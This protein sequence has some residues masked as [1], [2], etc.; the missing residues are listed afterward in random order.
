MPDF[1]IKQ[2]PYDLSGQA[3]L[4]LIGKYLKR[5]NF[6]AL[7]DPA[8]PVRS[9]IANSDILKSYLGLLCLGKND[10]DAIEGQRNDAFFLRALSLRAVPSSPTLR[11]RLDTHAASWFELA[12]R[13]NSAVL[14]L[15]IGGKPI[16]FG[17]LPCGY[18]PLDIDTFAMDNSGTA[19]EHV[20]RTYTGIDG[21]CP[22]AAYLGTQGFCLEL[23]LRPG[24]Q[25]SASETEYN[26]ERI[27][28][29][30][31]QVT[32]ASLLPLLFRADAGF[33]SAKLL[34]AIAQQAQALQ[35][36][37]AFIVKWNP[38][39]TPVE[40]IAQERLADTATVWSVLRQGKRQCCW[41]ETVQLKHDKT[42]I[43][44]RRVYR[45]T[46][47]T[48]D[49]RG[50]AMLLPEYVL[51]GWSTSLPERFDAQQI[52]DLYAD[53]GT[54][55]Q[56]HS[57][58]K[59]DMDLVRLP[60]GKFDTNYLVC[61]LA[62]VVMNLLRL[63]GQHTL[64]GPDAPLRHGAQRRRIRTVMQ[65]LMFKAARL[66]RHARHWVLGLGAN[67]RAFAVFQQHWQVLNSP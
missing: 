29:L 20:G 30:A 5:L 66:V 23:A 49:K 25:H 16:D 1:I 22:L 32:R 17:A 36:E 40:T 67:D 31:A 50:Q 37:V 62:A 13:I 28:P 46:E 9:G 43:N 47:R 63:V 8:F 6:N 51:E 56:F 26:I 42:A 34:C 44:V 38:R 33:D 39:S 54:H 65:E 52:M 2:L 3:G 10:F 53:H 7:V 41:S 12:E 57:E 15:K 18:V 58:F 21:Y 60:S 55:E 59:T 48:I 24:T 11:Q 35:R 4:A 19:K 64:H 45:L 14:S 27:V 61:A